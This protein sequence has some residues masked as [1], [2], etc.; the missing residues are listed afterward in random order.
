MEQ[1]STAAM[2]LA[3]P[4]ICLRCL[5]LAQLARSTECRSAVQQCSTTCERAARTSHMQAKS[6][7]RPGAGAA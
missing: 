4:L 2:Q 3:Q 5:P 7:A 6:P 1:P